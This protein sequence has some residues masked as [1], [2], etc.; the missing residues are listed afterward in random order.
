MNYINDD[1]FKIVYW[2]NSVNI[3]NYDNILEI[4]NDK[5]TLENNNKFIVIKGSNLTLNKLLDNEILI[6]GIISEIDL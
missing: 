6:V 2:N 4:N 1:R 5:I 3:I